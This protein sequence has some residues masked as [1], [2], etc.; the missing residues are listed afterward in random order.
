[1]EG[2]TYHGHLAQGVSLDSRPMEGAPCQDPLEQWVLSPSLAARPDDE[3]VVKVLNTK[4]FEQSVLG[5]G[6]IV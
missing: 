6:P 5:E 2:I 3:V 1:M 4:I